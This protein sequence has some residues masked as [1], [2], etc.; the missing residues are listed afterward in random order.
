MGVAAVCM[1]SGGGRLPLPS[2]CPLGVTA[3]EYIFIS[4]SRSPMS[5]W[6]LRNGKLLLKCHPVSPTHFTHT[7]TCGLQVSQL[8]KIFLKASR[9]LV[10]I[11]V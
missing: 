6:G 5:L 8:V 2:R 9:R 7:H 1:M 4:A 11:C 10:L 3:S